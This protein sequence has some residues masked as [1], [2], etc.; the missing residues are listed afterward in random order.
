[1]FCMCCCCCCM[2]L[3]LCWEDGKGDPDE[4]EDEGDEV[5]KDVEALEK[6]CCGILGDVLLKGTDPGFPAIGKKITD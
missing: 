1:M 3:L 6:G 2:E 5:G 4:A